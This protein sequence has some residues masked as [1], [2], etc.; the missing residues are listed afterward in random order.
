MIRKQK[1]VVHSV[2][3]NEHLKYFAGSTHIAIENHYNR[4]SL[5]RKSIGPQQRNAAMP[6]RIQIRS[7]KKVDVGRGEILYPDLN[8]ASRYTPDHHNLVVSTLALKTQIS[9]RFIK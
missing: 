1:E 3:Q 5:Q 4:P 7:S 6:V 8:V 2:S 9:D